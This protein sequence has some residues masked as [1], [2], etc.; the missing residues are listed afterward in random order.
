MAFQV[1]AWKAR[2]DSGY[3]GSDVHVGA[4]DAKWLEAW[5]SPKLPKLATLTKEH[6]WGLSA[7]KRWREKGVDF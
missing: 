6:Q 1:F 5:W 3:R 4:P 7:G 2:K